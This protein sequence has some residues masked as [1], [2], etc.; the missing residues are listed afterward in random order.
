MAAIVNFN[1]RIDPMKRPTRE[2]LLLE[3]GEWNRRHPV[4][5]AVRSALYPNRVLKTRTAATTLFD[6]KAVINLEGFDDYFD[7]HEISVEGEETSAS[8]VPAGNVIANA[9]V[10]MFPGQGAQKKG[11]GKD[12]FP[13]FP[14][15]TR[16][17]S[18]MLGYSIERLCLEDPDNQLG[19]TQFTQ[20]ALYVVG[21]LGYL[22][23]KQNNDPLV[24]ADFFIGHSLGEYNALFA[25]DAFDFETGLRLVIKRGELMGA[26]NGGAMAAVVRVDVE[27]IRKVLA[28]GGFD[29]IDVANFNTPTQTVISGPAAELAKAVEAFGREKIVAIPLKVSAA[30][31]SR[32]MRDARD[33]FAQFVSQFNFRAPRKP[34]IANV[35]A[36][37]YEPDRIAENLSDQIA[38]PVRWVDSVRYALAQQATEF[39]EIGSSIL[40]PMVKEIRLS[41]V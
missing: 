8:P 35:T 27:R 32:Y 13:A 37:P 34:V 38:S 6:Q 26:A 18:E 10:V 41:E 23:R 3:I 4:G 7:L 39:V 14:E 5:T 24:D 29:A 11:M 20:V 15:L 30:F 28:D 2:E 31:H 40:A 21:A 25:A 1:I 19:Q 22:Q 17:A 36:R 33:Q 9:K 12:L 16:R